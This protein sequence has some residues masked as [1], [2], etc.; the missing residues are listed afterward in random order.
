M[1]LTDSNSKTVKIPVKFIDGKFI[2]QLTGEEI[3]EIENESWC[4]LILH[5]HRVID[6]V[7]LEI[8]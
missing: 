1:L 8:L 5:A 7:L 4:E 3:H 6:D 2:N